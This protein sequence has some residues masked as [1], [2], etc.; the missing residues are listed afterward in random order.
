MVGGELFASD[1]LLQGNGVTKIHC[2]MYLLAAG[3]TYSFTMAAKRPV[4]ST[5]WNIGSAGA[6]KAEL[7]AMC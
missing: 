7:I 3:T 2:G 5:A 4:G 6:I 1:C